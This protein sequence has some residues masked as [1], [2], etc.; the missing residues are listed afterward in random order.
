MSQSS[1]S[2]LPTIEQIHMNIPSVAFASIIMGVGIIGNIHTLVVYGFFYRAGN[3]RQYVLWLST[4]DLLGCCITIPLYISYLVNYYTFQT[5]INCKMI[6]FFSTFFAGFSLAL[7]DIIAVDRYRR[8][9]NPL[10]K[11]LSR[12]TAKMV[13]TAACLV[14]VVIAIPNIVVSTSEETI[15]QFV[16]YS[17]NSFHELQ[18]FNATV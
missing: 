4:F 5:D 13:C 9:S 11:Q 1:D 16:N 3:H 8:M 14:N 7:L 10:K 12:R 2:E 6:T 18:N 15:T 17:S